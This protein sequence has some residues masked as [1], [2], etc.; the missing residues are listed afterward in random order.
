MYITY[1][2]MYYKCP[3]LARKGKKEKKKKMVSGRMDESYLSS[4]T[5]L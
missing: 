5:N 4:A 1:K 2:D 3:D